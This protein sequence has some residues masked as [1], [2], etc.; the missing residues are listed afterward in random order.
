MKRILVIGGYG[1]FGSYI[2][3]RLAPHPQI[4][5]IIG[6]RSEKKA[7][8]FAATLTDA[9]HTPE[10]AVLDITKDIS[11]VLK[12]VLPDMVIHTSGPFQE[13]GYAVAEACI[14]AGCHY[15]D[16]ADARS[17]V[18][19]ITALDQEAKQNAVAIISGASSVPCLSAAVIDHYQNRFDSIDSIDYGIA[20]AQQTNRG[21]ATTSAILSYVGHP[22]ETLTNGRM[23]T[24][25][26]WQN[27]RSHVYPEIGKRLL[28][29][30]DI[31]DLAL[32]PP[33]YPA[34]KNIRFGAGT[35]SRIQ[36]IGLWLLSFLPRYGLMKSLVPRAPLLYKIS[37]LFDRF[38]SGK[39]A[40]HMRLT[41]T[42]PRGAAKTLTFYIIAKSNHGPYIPSMPAIILAQKLAEG[43][44][45]P[46]GAYPCL[47]LITLEE[48]QDALGG[49][50]ITFL[51][52]DA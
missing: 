21:L 10:T 51:T 25:Y 22:F 52:E 39:S 42:D 16:L 26:G 46:Q 37:R 32:F 27:L 17:F 23:Q 33:R 41:G 43:K 19:S 24:T 48:Y 34:V 7:A 38:G 36:H 28:A 35:E 18:C 40:F 30:C 49:L 3:R 14:A 6:G 11:P 5:L 47:N 13:Q 44:E 20:T 29:D 45:L 15:T 31:P 4:R 8:D 2:C 50:D 12:A 9:A 1:N